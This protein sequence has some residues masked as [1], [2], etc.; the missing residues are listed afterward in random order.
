MLHFCDK[1]PY[2]KKKKGEGTSI[3]QSMNKKEFPYAIDRHMA[4]YRIYEVF[5][6]TLEVDVPTIPLWGIYP[7]NTKNTNS[8]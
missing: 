8:K 7:E 5:P 2:P 3:G 4:Y 6:K 1:G